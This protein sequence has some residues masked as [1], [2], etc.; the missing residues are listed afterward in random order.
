M[1]DTFDAVTVAVAFVSESEAVSS[2]GFFEWSDIID[3]AGSV[4]DVAILC[5]FAEKDLCESVRF[6]WFD[7]CI[8]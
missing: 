2:A 3:E 5:E 4:V 7:R 8:E 6:D 1:D